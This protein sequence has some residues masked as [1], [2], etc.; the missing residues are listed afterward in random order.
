MIQYGLECIA[1]QLV[2]LLM[3]DL[4]LKRETFFQWNRV[5]L[6]GTYA[7]SLILPWIKLEALRT[8]LPSQYAVRPNF[9]LRLDEVILVQNA[10][11]ALLFNFSWQE[12][13]FLTGMIIS[14]LLFG[15]KILQ[16]VRLKRNGDIH[17][18][19]D[20]TQVIVANSTMAFSFFK[21]IFIGD[22]VSKKDYESIIAHELVHI[23]QGHS[24]DLLFFELMR[25][26]CWFNPLVYGYQGRISELHEFIADAQAAKTNKKEQ[27][28]LLLSQ[29]FQ[30]QHI[31]FINPFF[32]SSL[33]KK[34]I[35]MLQ[36]SRSKKVWQLKYLVLLPL[37]LGM[38]FYTSCG[39]ELVESDAINESIAVIDI[40]NLSEEEEVRVFSRLIDLSVQPK[41]W[42]LKIEDKTSQIEFT[43]PDNE[44]S[45]ISGP[46]GIMI[47]A[48]MKIESKIL[49]QD[50]D[51][52]KYNPSNPVQVYINPDAV[53]F[54]LVEEVPIFPGCENAE[55]K[56]N[57]FKEKMQEH[58][59]KQFN[60]PEEAQDQGIQGRV[61]TLFLI[62]ADGSIK[63]ITAKGPDK[64]LEDEVLRIIQQLPKMTPGEAN[65]Q[66][67]DV[68]FS[69]PITFKLQ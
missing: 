19:R 55:D 66:P 48:K 51:I 47:K 27:Y 14:L 31:S 42:S 65:G 46:G 43:K 35:V 10:E 28:Q 62:A 32:K 17:Y 53:P 60:Y 63:D 3:Y 56:R 13:L 9:M 36:K 57:C 41:D 54:G 2:F 37:V 68:P 6:I 29:V 30:T 20:F 16:I 58:I 15:F 38:L 59:S 34:R 69:M 25:I 21:S 49:K 33:I 12:G 52:F 5:Y 39:R 44:D 61:N 7:V 11:E 22:K 23:K 40:E 64:L 8:T 24:C 26:L 4:F 67:V 45:G 1:F 18:F 50:F